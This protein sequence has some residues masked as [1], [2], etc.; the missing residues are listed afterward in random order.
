MNELLQ[1]VAGMDPEEALSKITEVLG[2]LLADLDEEAR[3]R[4]LMNMIGG[5]EGDKVSGLVYL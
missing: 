3:E 1:A 5:S 4:F 2:R